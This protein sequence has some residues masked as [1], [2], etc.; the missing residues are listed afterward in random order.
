[1]LYLF[2]FCVF[3]KNSFLKSTTHSLNLSQATVPIPI[4]NIELYPI[5]TLSLYAIVVILL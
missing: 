3:F 5:S 4:E 1:M 2:V